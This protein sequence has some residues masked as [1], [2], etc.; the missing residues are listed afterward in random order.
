MHP[1]K[2]G[3]LPNLIIS[4]QDGKAAG[5]YLSFLGAADVWNQASQSHDSPPILPFQIC[6]STGGLTTALA[7]LWGTVSPGEGGGVISG[8]FGYLIGWF[9]GGT[10]C[11]LQ[12][13]Y[14]WLMRGF[15]IGMVGIL[16]YRV[17]CL[18]L[19]CDSWYACYVINLVK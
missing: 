16:I 4:S 2:G 14:A 8:G 6:G 10:G 7:L 5:C 15:G 18:S 17:L 19:R 3:N 1:K 13:L 9:V 12:T 11:T